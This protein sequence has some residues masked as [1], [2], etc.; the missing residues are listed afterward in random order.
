M[1]PA[2]SFRLDPELLDDPPP[3]LGIGLHQRAERLR[4]LSFAWKD[5]KP[6]IDP[7]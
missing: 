2:T 6:K 4:C 7:C 3:F 1:F 5:F